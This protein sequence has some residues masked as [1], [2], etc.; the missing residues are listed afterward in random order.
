[1]R[2]RSERRDE[3]MSTKKYRKAYPRMT[4]A[5]K[6]AMYALFMKG[7]NREDGHVWVTFS[8]VEDAVA[9]IVMAQQERKEEQ[10]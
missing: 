8:D 10:R 6:D 2:N 7:T 1:M 3:S 4:D 5:Q 9:D